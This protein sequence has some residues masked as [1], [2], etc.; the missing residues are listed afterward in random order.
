[1]ISNTTEW[2]KRPTLRHALNIVKKKK[3]RIDY[4]TQTLRVVCVVAGA[5]ETGWDTCLGAELTFF[6]DGWRSAGDGRRFLL[7]GT[8]VGFV[9]RGREVDG[10]GTDPTTRRTNVP[11]GTPLPTLLLLPPVVRPGVGRLAS[12]TAAI[13]GC[14]G[15]CR[16]K[17]A[18]KT[19]KAS[20]DTYSWKNWS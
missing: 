10:G 5:A 8:G 13:T 7:A 6:N 18:T 20:E 2:H 16:R 15:R 14:S 1:M 4:C 17:R 9:A 3:T 19:D 12:V 11:D